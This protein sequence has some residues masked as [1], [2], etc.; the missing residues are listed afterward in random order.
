MLFLTG[1]FLEKSLSVDN[2]I[3]FIAIFGSFSI[4]PELQHR[5]LYYGILGAVIMRLLFVGLGSSFIGLFGDWALTA[6][7]LFVLWTAWKMWLI[8]IQLETGRYHQIRAQLAAEGC[9]IAG[10][11]K[12]GAKRRFAENTIALHHRQLEI[13]HPVKHTVIVITAP[14]PAAWPS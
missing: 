14:Y 6:F 10:D 1:Y 4:R 8:E 9:P 2:L 3:V 13:V 7:G 11:A 5:V 12:Y